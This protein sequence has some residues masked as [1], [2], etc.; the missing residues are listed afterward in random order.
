VTK[1]RQKNYLEILGSTNGTPT[2]SD[3]WLLTIK[4]YKTMA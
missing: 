3:M 4:L 2:W 1:E